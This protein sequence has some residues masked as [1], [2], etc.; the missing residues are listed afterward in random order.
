MGRSRCRS[1]RA[2]VRALTLLPDLD[3]RWIGKNKKSNLALPSGSRRLA[4]GGSVDLLSND[5]LNS[6]LDHTYG[7]CSVPNCG[8]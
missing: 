1:L 7:T 3:G 4:A 2:D 8:P 6:S 5:L